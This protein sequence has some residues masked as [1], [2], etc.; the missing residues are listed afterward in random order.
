MNPKKK[1]RQARFEEVARSLL[2]SHNQLDV[3]FSEEIGHIF[4]FSSQGAVSEQKTQLAINNVLHLLVIYKLRKL[5][6]K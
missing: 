3:L 2:P 5:V 1:R 4:L 6:K